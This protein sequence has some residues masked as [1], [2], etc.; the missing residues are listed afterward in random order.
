MQPFEPNLSEQLNEQFHEAYAGAK[1]RSKQECPVFVLLSDSLVVFHR[2]QRRADRYMPEVFH[3]LK[4]VAHVPVALYALLQRSETFDDAA[5]PKGLELLRERTRTWRSNLQEAATHLALTVETQ[6]DVCAILDASLDFVDRP[7]SG[8]RDD[9]LEAFAR[10]VGPG[11]LRLTHEATRLQLESL[12]ASVERALAPLSG[13]ER[14]ELQVVVT[15]DHQARA[16]SLGMQY[17]RQRLREPEDSEER[18]AYAEGVSDERE[19]FDLVGTRRLDHAV[20]AAFFGDRKRLQ[21]DIL[22]DSAAELLRELP[23]EPI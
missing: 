1:D 7:R 18:V 23:L 12:H 19:A 17:F 8:T 9:A 11:L 13:T 15:G 4:A 3:W 2:G 16:R 10:T 5:R 6:R 20:A 14:E 21:R 22:G